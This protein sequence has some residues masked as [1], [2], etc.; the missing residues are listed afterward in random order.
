MP[1]KGGKERARNVE[2]KKC[3][4]TYVAVAGWWFP[5]QTS[6]GRKKNIGI[7]PFIRISKRKWL[8]S[9]TSAHKCYVCL[10]LCMFKAEKKNCVALPKKHI[11]YKFLSSLYVYGFGFD[12]FFSL[13]VLFFSSRARA[14]IIFG[15]MPFAVT[16]RYKMKNIA[17][18]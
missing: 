6:N 15:K 1:T 12:F 17:S 8:F 11:V 2:R 5:T 9:F 7:S 3:C 4:S 10:M 14:S 13:C 16:K 18:S